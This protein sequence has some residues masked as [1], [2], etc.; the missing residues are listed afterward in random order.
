M[1]SCALVRRCGA[2]FFI[3]AVLMIFVL[4][5]KKKRTIIH[6]TKPVF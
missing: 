2:V 6:F 1:Q 3:T 4:V 5:L